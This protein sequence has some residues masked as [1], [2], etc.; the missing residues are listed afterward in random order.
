LP[1]FSEDL[2]QSAQPEPLDIGHSF[3]EEHSCFAESLPQ[4]H[5]SFLAVLA[6]APTIN[7]TAAIIIIDFNFIESPYSFVRYI[8]EY[9]TYGRG[10][11]EIVICLCKT[12]AE[13]T[14]LKHLTRSDRK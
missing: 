14:V 10:T 11:K 2:S 13:N 3:V 7:A 1:V 6:Q 12:W 5:E 8:K 9:D 4:A